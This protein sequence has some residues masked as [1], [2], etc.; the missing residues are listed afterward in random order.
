MKSF[1]LSFLVLFIALPVS[2]VY[3]EVDIPQKLQDLEKKRDELVKVSDGLVNDLRKIRKEIDSLEGGFSSFARRS[4]LKE[5]YDSLYDKYRPIY[6][7]IS[8]LDKAINAEIRKSPKLRKDV[9][10]EHEH[11]I[12]VELLLLS[13]WKTIQDELRLSRIELVIL[14]DVIDQKIRNSV[15]GEYIRQEDLRIVSKALEAGCR[16]ARSCNSKGLTDSIRNDI[17][18][19]NRYLRVEIQSGPP[20]VE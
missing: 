2:S 16:A 8:E 3:G 15:L 11:R 4:K 19:H 13:D 12:T 7:Q 10:A 20:D 17:K 6:R 18:G 14:N 1:S 5:K 9:F